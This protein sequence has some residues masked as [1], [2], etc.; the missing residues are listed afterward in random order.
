MK[1]L[2]RANELSRLLA[3]SKRREGGLA[4]VTGRRRV[5]KTRL[6]VEWVER[7]GGVYF[8]ADQSSPAVLAGIAARATDAK[9][10][11]PL[12]IDELPYLVL[13]APELPSA[14]QHFIDHGA[15]RA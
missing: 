2:D 14:L 15:R 9:W 4:V 13:Q 5:G 3:L 6:L 1:F 12:V 10:R 7:V 8:V 11:G